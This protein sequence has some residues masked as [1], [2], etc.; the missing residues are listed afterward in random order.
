VITPTTTLRQN[1]SVTP[2]APRKK[3]MFSSE[4]SVGT[5]ALGKSYVASRAVTALTKISY[6][7]TAM[8]RAR[9]NA[10]P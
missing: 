8:Y 5:I 6:S 9:A 2:L 4:T 7:G 1:A 10:A 3:V